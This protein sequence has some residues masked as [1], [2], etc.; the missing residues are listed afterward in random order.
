MSFIELKEVSRY[1]GRKCALDNVTLGFERSQV[2]VLVGPNGA[3]KTTLLSCLSTT[4]LPDRGVIS[5]GGY[6]LARPAEVKSMRSVFRFGIL[7]QQSNLYSE[8]TPRENLELVCSLIMQPNDR[9][10]AVEK[11][12]DELNLESFA[13]TPCREL[14]QG[15]LKRVSIARAVIV[16]PDILLLDEPCSNLDEVS[17]ALVLKLLDRERS[18]GCAIVVASH[19]LRVREDLA[20]VVCDFDSGE[21]MSSDF[22]S[23]K[24]FSEARS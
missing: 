23:D 5:I 11:A 13:D 15:M 6:N 20:D 9:A 4:L 10:L 1:F 21:L 2:S 17:K 24:R 3:G 7:T 22:V 18:C 14:S 19:D 12:I 16:K 8:L